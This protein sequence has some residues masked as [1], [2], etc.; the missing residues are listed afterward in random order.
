MLRRITDGLPSRT[1][2]I[3]FLLFYL[4]GNNMSKTK[5]ISI[6][7]A[8]TVISNLV[9]FSNEDGESWTKQDLTIFL[10][11]MNHYNDFCALQKFIKEPIPW[12]TLTDIFE[13][14]EVLEDFIDEAGEVFEHEFTNAANDDQKADIYK[15]YITFYRDCRAFEKKLPK[16]EINQCISLS[17][18]EDILKKFKHI[19][20]F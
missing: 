10:E 16:E 9:I 19:I 5:K 11:A 18:F 8:T 20:R 7:R 2:I 3:N 4:G 1:R 6:E 15:S 12:E 14:G 13:Y 17:T